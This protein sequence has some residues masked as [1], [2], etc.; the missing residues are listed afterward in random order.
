MLSWETT[1]RSLGHQN[2]ASLYTR[3]RLWGLGLSPCEHTGLM[4]WA[5]DVRGC[6]HHAPWQ[7][8][9][10]WAR[11][12]CLPLSFS[13]LNLKGTLPFSEQIKEDKTGLR[14]RFPVHFKLFLYSDIP[15]FHLCLDPRRARIY[16]LEQ[17][18]VTHGTIPGAPTPSPRTR[19]R[20]VLASQ[21]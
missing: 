8:S 13:L 11:V 4:G 21:D 2:A 7:R 5:L 14:T 15:F 20:G 9:K 10:N 1:S 12:L 6:G 19:K 16:Q 18:T 3:G 17:I